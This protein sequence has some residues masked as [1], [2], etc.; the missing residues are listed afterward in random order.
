[1][2]QRARLSRSQERLLV[3]CVNDLY[4]KVDGGL[5]A[6]VLFN[7]TGKS[8][9]QWRYRRGHE[10]LRFNPEAFVLDW[11]AHYPSTLA[12]EVAHS[13]VFRRHG[14]AVRP[15][16][17]EWKTVML[18]LGYAPKRTHQTMLT[19]RKTR[20]YV[21]QCSC[22]TYNV[23]PQRHALIQKKGY[24]YACRYCKDQLKFCNKINMPDT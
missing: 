24:F 17:E 10:I 23:S 12:H 11:D 8:A 22:K 16:G 19:S 1:M 18:Q 14:R 4:R 3:A 21:Y 5:P 20:V 9:G 13:V 7:L 2:Q 15:H 6:H